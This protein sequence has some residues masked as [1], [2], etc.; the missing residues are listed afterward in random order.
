MKTHVK[1]KKMVE[2]ESVD[3]GYVVTINEPLASQ[4]YICED[5][6]GVVHRLAHELGVV[7]PGETVTIAMGV[8]ANYVP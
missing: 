6:P 8:T 4:K 7:D 5:F 3:N 2:I 1:T